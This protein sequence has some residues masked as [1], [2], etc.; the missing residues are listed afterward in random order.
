M[1]PRTCTIAD[2]GVILD[3]MYAPTWRSHLLASKAHRV[4]QGLVGGCA[5]LLGVALSGCAA[6]QFTY[7]ANSGTNTYFKVPYS[8]HKISD[9]SLSSELR[10]VTG[11]SGGGWTVAYE[12][13]PELRFAC[14]TEPPPRGGDSSAQP[15]LVRWAATATRLAWRPPRA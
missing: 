2:E 3:T 9:S 1:P 8:W 10:T 11:S 15:A 4:V 13:G 6:P 14:W 5:L 12:A 7:V